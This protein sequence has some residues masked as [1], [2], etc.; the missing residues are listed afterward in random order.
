MTTLAGGVA[1]EFNNLLVPIIGFSKMVLKNILPGS[2]DA[3]YL[4][5]VIKTAYRAKEIVLQVKTFRRKQELILE[6]IPLATILDQ[7]LSDMGPTL[8]EN[9]VLQTEIDRET[10]P[11]LSNDK[12]IQQLIR[13]LVDN[14]ADAM[15]DGGTLRISLQNSDIH[16][17]MKTESACVCLTFEDT[18]HGM[19]A[20]IQE[21]IFN[22]FFTT[23]D[24]GHHTGL[25]LSVSLGIMDQLDGIIDVTS[26][27]GIGSLFKI[28][29]PA[30]TKDTMKDSRPQTC[31]DSGSSPE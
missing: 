27:S 21:Q 24:K 11:V 14:A 29:F 3:G 19:K 25:G 9:I 26:E 16:P 22:P 12:Q 2:Q 28:Y 17:S 30:F 18:G 31:P 5:R 8:P 23:R 20:E 10:L 6:S 1:H 15:P 4:E 7:V 13:N